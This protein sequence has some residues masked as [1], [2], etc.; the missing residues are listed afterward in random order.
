ME[1]RCSPD[2]F[3]LP[4]TKKEIENSSLKFFI[5]EKLDELIFDVKK[6]ESYKEEYSVK[7][8]RYYQ[9]LDALLWGFGNEFQ[10]RSIQMAFE[11]LG[12]KEKEKK[13]F[14]APR[15]TILISAKR[16]KN[17]GKIKDQ[18]QMYEMYEKRFSNRI[19]YA[20]ILGFDLAGA[21]EGYPPSV[22]SDVM[23]P[24]FEKCTNMTIHAGEETD[25]LYIWQSIY[26]LHATRIGHGLTLGNDLNLLQ[27]AKEKKFC[28]EMCPKSNTLTNKYSTNFHED[29]CLNGTNYEQ[30][31]ETTR[32]DIRLHGRLRKEA[33]EGIKKILFPEK[34][35][36]EPPY[37]LRF[38]YDF[39]LP[40][41]ICTDNP[42][43]SNASMTEEY[44]EACRRSEGF[45]KWDILRII[46]MGFKNA[47]LPKEEVARM[48]QRIGNEI[49]DKVLELEKIESPYRP[50]SG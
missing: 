19:E 33:Y 47:F 14:I 1:L 31:L 4:H 36:K 35:S 49:Y 18:V 26:K 20:P 30:L 24:L 21:E 37:P 3:V 43:I 41:A 6:P 7:K 9:V 39:G 23:T 44:M 15:I 8:G 48:L 42:C 34:R 16:H 32:N 2:G 11:Y 5:S 13:N 50:S 46:K 12:Q 29:F 28:I 40:V 25:W 45:S 27:L 10:N 17:M 22:F 38:Y